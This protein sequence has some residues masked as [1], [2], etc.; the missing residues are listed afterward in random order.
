M[1]MLKASLLI[2]P[3]LLLS[4]CAT[5]NVE[6]APQRNPP[7]AEAFSA[8]GRFELRPVEM[9]PEHYGPSGSYRAAQRIQEHFDERLRPMLDEWTR[10]ADR[11]ATRTLRIEPRIERIQYVSTTYRILTGPYF[12]DSAVAMTLKYIDGST[13]NVIA[14]P[15]F[16]LDTD[17]W[18]GFVTFGT[19]D[20]RMLRRIVDVVAEYTAAHYRRN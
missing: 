17:A 19:Q 1:R 4:A 2:L 11:K 6:V 3:A 5:K 20:N 16:F 9:A 10:K 13:G 14:E 7:P 18:W 15:Q 8:F 12:G